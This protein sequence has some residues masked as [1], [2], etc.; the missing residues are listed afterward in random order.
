[1]QIKFVTTVALVVAAEIFSICAAESATSESEQEILRFKQA[2]LAKL[3]PDHPRFGIIRVLSLLNLNYP[4]LEKVKAATEAK[5]VDVA[6]IDDDVYDDGMNKELV[7]SYHTMYIDLFVDIYNLFKEP[8]YENRIP[9]TYYPKLVKMVDIYAM[10]SFPDLTIC[11]FGD[12]PKEVWA[13]VK[14]DA[15]CLRYTLKTG[16]TTQSV[17][18][19]CMR[20]SARFE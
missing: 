7:F 18:L 12:A 4:G 8:G 16:D 10:Q 1:M 15:S 20:K 17:R 3:Q 5:Q 13:S 14:A 6:E 2:W 11:Q 9:S 19:D